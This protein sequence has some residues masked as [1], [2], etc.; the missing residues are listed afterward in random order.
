MDWVVGN[1]IDNPDQVS[2]TSEHPAPTLFENLTRLIAPRSSH[3]ITPPQQ[4]T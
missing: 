4:P 1:S 2:D 3:E